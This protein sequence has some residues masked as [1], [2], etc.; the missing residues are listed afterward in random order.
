VQ[1]RHK[2]LDEEYKYMAAKTIL[3]LKEGDGISFV[4]GQKFTYQ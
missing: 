1:R 3:F 4:D 2:R